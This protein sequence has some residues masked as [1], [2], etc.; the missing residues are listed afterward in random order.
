[1]QFPENQ[2]ADR[3]ARLGAAF[4]DGIIIMVILLPIILLTNLNF[5][6]VG[7]QGM[8]LTQ[9][10]VIFIL[11]I[12]VFLIPNGYLLYSKGQTVGKMIL[13]MKI[14]DADGKVPDFPKL[15]TLRYIVLYLVTRIP[16]IGSLLALADVLFIFTAERRC[17]HDQLAGTWVVKG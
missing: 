7:W 10:L 9:H 11:G 12:V 13:K 5:G 16:F 17:L 2:L 1:M 8:S 14:V 15:L 3:W 4:I 6:G